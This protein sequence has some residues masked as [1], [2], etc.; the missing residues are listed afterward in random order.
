[1]SPRRR[2]Q[3]TGSYLSSIDNTPT[4]RLE[5]LACSKA[6]FES[7]NEE[8]SWSIIDREILEWQYM[9]ETGRP[10]WWSQETKHNRLD[11]LTA[12]AYKN[13]GS[14]D[15][16]NEIYGG[17]KPIYHERRRTV[18]ES[19]LAD[20]SNVNSLAHMIA[21]QLL[22]SCFTLPPDHATSLRSADYTIFDKYGVLTVPD[23]RLISSL[24]LHSHFRYSPCFGHEPRNTSPVQSWPGIYDG[25][26]SP[27]LS[28]QNNSGSD[29][30]ASEARPRRRRLRRTLNV[31]ENSECS[32]DSTSEDG[33]MSRRNTDHTGYDEAA[34]ACSRRHSIREAITQS[35]SLPQRMPR[36]GSL[37]KNDRPD[38]PMNTSIENDIVNALLPNRAMSGHQSPRN[39]RLQPVLRSEPHHVFVQP[40]KE[41]VIKPWRSLRRRVGGSMHSPHCFPTVTP[42]SRRSEAS[43]SGQSCTSTSSVTPEGRA[44][45]R[46]AQE[47]GDIYSSMDSTQHNTTPANGMC[48]E[49]AAHALSRPYW[50]DL[51]TASPR[52][53]AGCERLCGSAEST[54]YY[55][56]PAS[57]YLTPEG[58]T[59][60]TSSW[61]DSRNSSP[62][63]QIPDPI[64]AALAVPNCMNTP[65]VQRDPATAS[66][67]LQPPPSPA[68]WVMATPSS[69]SSTGQTPQLSSVKSPN[70]GNT[71]TTEF[72]LRSM[73]TPPTFQYSSMRIPKRHRRTS[74]LSEVCTPEDFST[75][76]AK[77]DDREAAERSA[78][79]ARGTPLSTPIEEN[80]PSPFPESYQIPH[81]SESLPCEEKVVSPGSNLSPGIRTKPRVKR[82]SRSGSQIFTPDDEGVE[83]NGLPTGPGKE[84]WA[85]KGGRRER[86]YL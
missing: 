62:R 66:T 32:L 38:P 5:D 31:T 81:S 78:W 48:D 46:R 35:L 55:N 15:W 75:P 36:M 40:V 82:L 39:N 72:Q 63:F 14:H 4:P 64:A 17:S 28:R 9:C 57:G 50:L 59:A 33:Y 16:S 43:E 74:L 42:E 25:P 10:Y 76:N 1:M 69:T 80:I 47:R 85:A 34:A 20:A 24:R 84:M 3:R 51:E 44:R 70:S 6:G 11:R 54:P 27:A 79:S 30:D 13:S 73:Q 61:L 18:S 71:S 56:S 68:S 7:A 29:M 41:L 58:S 65:N 22:G 19:Y 8:L 67:P 77:T 45:R 37:K 60:Q 49:D 53:K 83:L 26:L 2:R 23:P 86:T 12:V 21:I 52:S